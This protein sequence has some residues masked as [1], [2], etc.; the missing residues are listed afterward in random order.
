MTDHSTPAVQR[1]RLRMDDPARVHL[2]GL[3]GR[4]D[5]VPV[6]TLS[7]VMTLE[8]MEM[9]DAYFPEAPRRRED[10]PAGANRARG[11]RYDTIM[12][13]FHSQ[14]EA[15]AIGADTWWGEKDNWPPPTSRY[16]PTPPTSRCRTTTWTAVHEDGH[17]RH[18][19]PAQALPRRRLV[20]KVYPLV[21]RLHMVGVESFL[22]DVI[23]D[24]DKIKRYVEAFLPAA[25]E[26]AARSSRRRRRHH[27][28][29]PHHRRPL[30]RRGLPRLSCIDPPVGE[31]NL[32]ADHLPLLRPNHRPGALL[33][34]GRLR[35]LPLRV[36]GGRRQGARITGDQMSLMGNINN[37]QVLLQGRPRRLR[38]GDVRVGGGRAGIAPEGSV[39]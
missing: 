32:A 3:R 34:A 28:V 22:M 39:P 21:A 5:R 19:D 29:R 37:P 38:P 15:A 33:H 13:W 4:V 1:A 26:S 11:A 27:V 14:L 30:P 20:G 10:G 17:R 25:F 6:A 35:L 8:L 23:L 31:P 18:Q 24:P 16:S 2:R 9:A 12:R 36:A 7:S